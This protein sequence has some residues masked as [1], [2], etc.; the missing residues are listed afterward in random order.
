VPHFAPPRSGQESGRGL[1]VSHVSRK[2]F[3]VVAA[4]DGA[5][6]D[7]AEAGARVRVAGEKLESPMHFDAA[8]LERGVP[9]DLG[10]AVLLLLHAMPS[11][12]PRPPGGEDGAP[13]L[14]GENSAVERIRRQI[15]RVANH[16]VPVLLRGE[17]GT[18]KEL[19]ARAVHEA[20]GRVGKPFVSVNLAAVPR[21]TAAAA[22]FGH[23]KGAFT[24]AIQAAHGYFG[25]ADG[26]TLF[27]DEVGEAPEEVQVALLRALETGEVQPV[28]GVWTCASSPRPTPTSR[29][30]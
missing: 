4:P 5:R 2:P 26:G 24:G 12:R 29:R 21:S 19:V 6:L 15:E 1:G 13:T 11:L 30:A 17:S 16:D 14:V 8:A 28:G 23:A 7:P 9:I 3:V 20:S 10:G 22:L 27:L 18:G 25:E